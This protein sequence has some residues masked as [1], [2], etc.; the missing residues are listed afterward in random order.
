MVVANLPDDVFFDSA[1]PLES[2]L[3][4]RCSLMKSEALFQTNHL[5]QLVSTL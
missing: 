4:P 1:A 2:T 5:W 3:N